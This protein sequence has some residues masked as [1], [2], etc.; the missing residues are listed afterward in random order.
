MK[1]AE[2]EVGYTATT[3]LLYRRRIRLVGQFIGYASKL[4]SNIIG[5]FVDLHPL[6]RNHY[7][8][9]AMQGSFSIKKVAP[10]VAPDLDYSALED[11][12]QG[13]QASEAYLEILAPETSVERRARLIEALREYCK[14]D[15]WAM[16]RVAWALGG[17][18]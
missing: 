15:T 11:I 9:P 16:V 3:F 6:V 7:Y 8:H 18:V 17:Q 4:I 12:T 2:N 1:K 14:L 13:A 5:R 10:T